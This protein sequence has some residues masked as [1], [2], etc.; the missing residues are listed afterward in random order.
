MCLCWRA[1][2]VLKCHLITNFVFA[3]LFRYNFIW[4][5]N[6]RPIVHLF[7]S[8]FNWCEFIFQIQMKSNR[9]SFNRHID[10]HIYTTSE[11]VTNGLT[12]YQKCIRRLAT[13]PSLCMAYRFD[14]LKWRI[15]VTVQIEFEGF[16]SRVFIYS[17]FLHLL[18]SD[19]IIFVWLHVCF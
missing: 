3:S 15:E 7:R 17:L 9:S 12:E 1:Q 10:H 2:S 8:T 19:G 18:L 4:A 16:D 11:M 5:K 6:I 13:L 14:H